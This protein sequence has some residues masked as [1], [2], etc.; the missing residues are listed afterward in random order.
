MNVLFCFWAAFTTSHHPPK[1][2]E[3]ADAVDGDEGG[4]VRRDVDPLQGTSRRIEGLQGFAC[5]HVP[6]LKE[7]KKKIK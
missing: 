7:P 3:D 2:V 5:L 4:E 6:P 1:N